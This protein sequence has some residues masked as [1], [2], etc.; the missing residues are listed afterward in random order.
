MLTKIR[1]REGA[2]WSWSILFVILVL[3]RALNNSQMLFKIDSHIVALLTNCLSLTPL[4]NKYFE[5]IVTKRAIVTNDHFFL[6][7][8]C[9][10]LDLVVISSF[11]NVPVL[12]TRC[13]QS[14]L[15]QI[16]C[17]WVIFKQCFSYITA[18]NS[19]N[20]YLTL[21]SLF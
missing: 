2:S 15:W 4:Q 18:D 12:Y 10:K 6:F 13:F 17:M 14:H 19:F 8:Q 5:N 21:I 11:V 20:Q 7:P 3:N 9:F 16:I 1:L